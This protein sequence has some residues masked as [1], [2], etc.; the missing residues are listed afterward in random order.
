MKSCYLF[1]VLFFIA[2]LISQPSFSD[3]VLVSWGGGSQPGGVQSN[4]QFGLDYSFL[5]APRSARSRLSLGVSFTRMTTDYPSAQSI[6]AYSVYP[7]LTLIPQAAELDGFFFYVR[8]LGPSY[9]SANSLGE[10]QQD[11]HFSFQAQLGVGYE[12]HLEA[13]GSLLMLLSR[14]HFSNANLFDK[15]DGIDLPLVL[16]LGL[17]F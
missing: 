15:N 5:E 12:F 13:G 16:S 1:T 6:S 3:E 11:N 14:K 9:I 7:Q 4:R 8:A 2:A 10:R 17:R